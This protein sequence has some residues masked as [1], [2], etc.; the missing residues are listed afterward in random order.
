MVQSFVY[1][2]DEGQP[3]VYDA[4]LAYANLLFCSREGV[5]FDVVT[6]NNPFEI[7]GSRQV[8]H[9]LSFGYLKFPTDFNPGEKIQII[10]S[11]L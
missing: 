6:S 1:N 8:Q 3:F 4:A 9:S 5:E 2:T 11:E 10:I 7:I